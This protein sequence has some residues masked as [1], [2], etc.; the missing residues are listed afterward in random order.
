MSVTRKDNASQHMGS[1]HRD[2]RSPRED[3]KVRE[4]TIAHRAWPAAGKGLLPQSD[5]AEWLGANLQP[6][7]LVISWAPA[8]A[9]FGWGASGDQMA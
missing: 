2:F 7:R 9:H 4:G 6:S 1:L 5:E 3:V 8:L